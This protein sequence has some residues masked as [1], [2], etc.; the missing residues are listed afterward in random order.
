[1][2]R[3]HVVDP[4][5]DTGPG[6]DL[7]NGP[8]K[9]KQLNIFKGMANNPAVLKAFLG[10]SQGVKGHELTPAEHEIIALVVAERNECHYCTAAHTAVANQLGID[11]DL[12]LTI[13]RGE[14]DDDRQQAIIDFVTAIM[15]TNG[16]VNDEHLE[17][18]RAAGFNDAAVVEVIAQ[19]TV[20][21]FTNLFNH[22]NETEIDFPEPAAV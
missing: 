12:A 20:M 13:R 8:L 14:A 5:T 3:L 9:G 21:T 18:F 7:L 6:A 22:V 15:D 16:F 17:A 19:I 2:P 10:F 11:D 1:M 4:Q